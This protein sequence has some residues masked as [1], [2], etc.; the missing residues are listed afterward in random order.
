MKRKISIL[1][2]LLMLLSTV[3]AFASAGKVTPRISIATQGK[4]V[5]IYSS[6]YPGSGEAVALSDQDYATTAQRFFVDGRLTSLGMHCPSFG[7]NIGNITFKL[8]Q[9]NKDYKTTIAGK[10]LAEKTYENF[11]DNVY[12]SLAVPGNVGGDLLLLLCNPVEKVAAWINPP[13]GGGG[14]NATL[15]IDGEVREGMAMNLEFYV[16]EKNAEGSTGEA[17]DAYAP[18]NLSNAPLSTAMT[19]G[20]YADETWTGLYVPETPGYVAY[21]VD[22]GNEA[23]KGATLR[24]RNGVNDAAKVQVIADDLDTGDIICEFY[25]EVEPELDFW[26]TITSKIHS[27]I[28]GEHTIYVVQEYGNMFMFD[29]EFSKEALEP[30]WDEKRLAEFEATKDFTLNDMYSDTWAGTD[31]LGRKL[32]DFNTAGEFNP[33]KQVGLFYW[34]WHGGRS[35]RLDVT[36]IQRAINRYPGE[37]VEIKNNYYDKVWAS[38]S[39]IWNE[40]IYGFYSGFDTWVMRKQLELFNAAGVDG[41]FFDASNGTDVWTGSYMRLAKTM[42]EMHLDGIKTPGMS[43]ILPFFDMSY[44]VTDLERIYESMYSVGLYSDTW[45]YWDGKPVVMGYP[46]NLI[47]DAENDERLAQHQEILD[48]FTFRPGQPD[49]RK[50]LYQENQWPWLEVYPQHP[51]GESEKYGCECVSVGIAQNGNDEGLTAMNG[52][53]VYGRSF[54][55][56]DRFKKYSSTSKYYGYNFEEQWERAFEL[57]PEFVFVT[58]WNEWSVGHYDEWEGVKGAFPDQYNDEYSRDIEPTKGALKDNYYMQFAGKIR[59]FKGVRPTPTASAEKTIALGDF[60]AFADVKPEFHGY[61]GGTEPRDAYLRSAGTPVTNTTGRNDIVLSKVARDSEN[62]YFYVETTNDLTPHTDNS[63]MRLLI[64]TDR[65]YK[66][67]W[68][69]YDFVLNRVSPTENTATLEKWNGTH[70]TDWKWE[71]AG[72]VDY[73]YSGNKMMVKIPKALVGVGENVDIEFKWNDNMVNQ[74]DI[75]DFYTNGD[76]AP[77][78]RFNYRYVDEASVNNKATD[79]PVD[80]ATGMPHLTQRFVVMAIGSNRAY[81]YGDSV[82][83]DT[84]SEVTAPVIVNNKTMLPVRFLAESIGA[85][86]EWIEDTQTVRIMTNDQRITLQLGSN[87]MKVEKQQKTLQSPAI[88]IENR[89]YVPLRDIV[90]AI[91]V[92]C[93]WIEPGLILCGPQSALGELYVTNGIDRILYEF[94][95]N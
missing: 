64:N 26:Q 67:G 94:G 40:S 7:N 57:N 25:A 92:E 58:G 91:G 62:L 27:D 42:H 95:M 17:V 75:M 41:L 61:K 1:L 18:Y 19:H 13:T 16:A 81:V 78:G 49:Y 54:T 71:T 14:A 21:K 15:Y 23:P 44:N 6:D 84:E 77:I 32:P 90:E 36:N 43:F 85:N 11:D 5:V 22:F 53:G 46:N 83:V 63:W 65:Q 76:T 79:E 2:A 3:S 87:I 82:R 70:I 73:T 30:S 48:F 80:P 88:E 20:E 68:E 93:H 59:Q 72:Q 51:Y 24:I 66:T 37:E 31:S 55:Y 50:G 4:K 38:A 28:T 45:Y 47:K 56:K 33:D 8:F 35:Q 86:V 10:V 74:G 69:G 29:L 52:E 34:T 9:W 89:I 60:G 39:Y 12:I